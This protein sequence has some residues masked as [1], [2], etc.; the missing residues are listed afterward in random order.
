MSS[1]Q[2]KLNVLPNVI[3]FALIKINGVYLIR[4][5]QELNVNIQGQNLD[6]NLHLS[7]SRAWTIQNIHLLWRT[8]WYAA[9][10]AFSW[11]FVPNAPHPVKVV[12]NI[13]NQTAFLWNEIK[14]LNSQ[15]FVAHKT[16]SVSY[17]GDH[18]QNSRSLSSVQKSLLAFTACHWVEYRAAATNYFVN[19]QLIKSC[20]SMLQLTREDGCLFTDN[21]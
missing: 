10:H 7:I 18:V 17:L 13:Q 14:F 9:W 15:T 8:Y 11:P 2:A 3:S 4:A 5:Q 6:C 20:F 19:T 21:S 16:L 1:L 12:D